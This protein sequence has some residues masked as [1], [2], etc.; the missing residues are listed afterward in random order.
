M[1]ASATQEHSRILWFLPRRRHLSSSSACG[2]RRGGAM[3][4]TSFR[5]CFTLLYYFLVRRRRFLGGTDGTKRCGASSTSQPACQCCSFTYNIRT[6]NLHI[7]GERI[8]DREPCSFIRHS[9]ANEWQRARCR[10]HLTNA[11]LFS[12]KFEFANVRM[13]YLYVYES[14]VAFRTVESVRTALW[15]YHLPG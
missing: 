11:N 13:P 14:N 8:T 12:K 5:F 9:T 4:I 1:L 7:A 10:L 2:R 15:Y 3:L 6:R